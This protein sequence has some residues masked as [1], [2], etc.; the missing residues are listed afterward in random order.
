MPL[1][2][3]IIQFQTSAARNGCTKNM[4]P[5]VMPQTRNTS[6]VRADGSVPGKSFST[7]LASRYPKTVPTVLVIRSLTSVARKVKICKSSMSRE[8]QKPNRSVY[9]KALNFFQKRGRKKPSGTN[10]S[11]FSRL[12]L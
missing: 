9:P 6:F 2:S 12:L 8:V 1:K 10:S 4:T 3:H 11:T 7:T 5:K